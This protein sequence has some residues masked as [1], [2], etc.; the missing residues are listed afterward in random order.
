MLEFLNPIVGAASI[1]GL[2]V[3]LGGWWSGHGTHRLTCQVDPNT[4]QLL[5]AI[6]AHAHERPQEGMREIIADQLVSPHNCMQEAS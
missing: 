2:I 5:N 4:Q 3:T 1:I 6:D